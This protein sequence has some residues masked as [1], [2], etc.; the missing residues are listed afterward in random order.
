MSFLAKAV[1]AGAAKTNNVAAIALGLAVIFIGLAT[2]QLF[3]YEDFAK[4]IELTWIP[5]GIKSATIFVAFIVVFEVFALPFLLRMNVSSLM[6][7]VSM[8]SGWVTLGMW[9]SLTL[10]ENL[11]TN[12]IGSAGILGATISTPVGWWTT[13][14]F[15]AAAVLAGWVSWGMWPTSHKNM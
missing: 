3:S 10:W 15:M 2:A 5:G 6:R 14:V 4:V 12:P 13:L 11:S 7:W 9:L 1:P 8:I